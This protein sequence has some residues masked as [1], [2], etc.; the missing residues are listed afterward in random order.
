MT[1]VRVDGYLVQ[2][3][4]EDALKAIVGNSAWEGRELLVPGTRRRWDMA[5]ELGSK[6][7]VVEFDGD[8]HYRDPLKM[9]VDNEKDVTARSL[10]YKVVRMPY[11]VQLT[12]QTLQ[13]YFGLSAEIYQ[14]FPHGFIATKLFPASYCEMG[15]E[16]FERELS[17]L[18][19]SVKD[20][21]MSSLVDRC[22]EHGADYVLPRKLRCIAPQ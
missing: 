4:L 6:V 17:S 11:W 20:A 10:G 13:H 9:K 3:K 5:Y 22:A 19:N 18:P 7:T 12:N 14:D 2:K 21:V 16:R 1:E 15:I 8:A